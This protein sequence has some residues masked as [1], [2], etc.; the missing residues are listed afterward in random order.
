MAL[1]SVASVKDVAHAGASGSPFFNIFYPERLVPLSRPEAEA[2]V[3][4]PGGQPGLP[5]LVEEVL[6]LAGRHPYLIQLACKCAWELREN[7]DGSLERA[8]L[9][10][11]FEAKAEYQYQYVWDHSSTEEQRTLCALMEGTRAGG[12]G[13]STLLERGYVVD[14]S[15]PRLDGSGFAAFVRSRCT[16]KPVKEVSE[17]LP[18]SP[19]AWKRRVALVIGVNEYLHQWSG[20]YHLA[21]LQYA[22]RDA[23]EIGALLSELGYAVTLLTGKHA[24]RAVVERAFADLHHATTGVSS[25]DS[26]FVFHFSGHGQMD[27]VD[28][29]TAYLVLHD[30]DPTN[31]AASGL[32][33]ARLASGLVPL[34]PTTNALVLLDAC[35]AGFAA[36]IARHM[37]VVH[38]LPNI[39]QQLFSGLRGRMVLAACVGEAQARELDDL[40]HGVFTHYV[41]KHWRDLDGHH[42]PDCITF[43]SLVDYVGQMIPQMHPNFPLPVYNGVGIGSTVILRKTQAPDPQ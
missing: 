39:A 28:D 18:P 36:G 42:Q 29:E 26:C 37:G 23:L 21:T 13:V 12:G 19:T 6:A 3:A 10:T 20:D 41:L 1:A 15:P 14:G 5:D 35:H 30:T 16:C 24:T 33:M 34:I 32:E 11:A 8:A 17:M 4:Q 9:Q 43:G 2:L 25:G 38:R 40:G 7:A 31:P 22:E 27:P